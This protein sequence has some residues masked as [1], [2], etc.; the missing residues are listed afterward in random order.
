MS[1]PKYFPE[2]SKIF[3]DALEDLKG[4][5]VAI[6]GHLRPD[7]DCIGSQIA[8]CRVL[9]TLGIE[10]VAI[11]EDEVPSYL[12]SFIKDTP[13]IQAKDVERDSYVGI[14]VDC[15]DCNRVGDYLKE[16]SCS[17]ILSIDH[18]LSNEK[19]AKYNILTD[20]ASATAEILAGIFFDDE[21][22][23]DDVTAEALYLGIA[24][25]TGQFR[26]PATSKRVFEIC[27]ELIERGASPSGVAYH[28]FE[29]QRI[30][31]LMLLKDFLGTIKL[32]INGRACIGCITQEMYR[33]SGAMKEDTEGFVDYLRSIDGVEIGA[34]I[35][36]RPDGVKASLRCLEH[37][38]RVD[39]LAKKFNG[40]GHAC[41]AGLRVDDSLNEFYPKFIKALNEHIEIIDGDLLGK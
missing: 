31:K 17:S 15:A 23:V 35:E 2:H 14:N 41:A 29:C 16:F 11:N 28:L 4:K 39:L 13:F 26:F 25:D 22:P 32:E 30:E 27:T 10:A 40:G 37:R 12:K 5:K 38:M 7:G 36:E 3:K 20:E 34:L 33:K 8:L 18:H 19:F 1:K 21:L 6:M 9:N 24:T